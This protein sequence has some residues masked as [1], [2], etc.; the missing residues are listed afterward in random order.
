MI[1]LAEDDDPV[2]LRATIVTDEG[3][4]HIDIHQSK[5]HSFD[6]NVFVEQHLGKPYVAPLLAARANERIRAL[7]AENATLR[8]TLSA[9]VKDNDSGDRSAPWSEVWNVARN[10]LKGTI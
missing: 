5:L 6:K 2:V 4:S 10:L 3:V 8:E 7:E 9:L 1:T